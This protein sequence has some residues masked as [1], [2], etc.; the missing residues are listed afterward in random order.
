MKDKKKYVAP[1]EELIEVRVEKGFEQ[2]LGKEEELNRY[3]PTDSQRS[4]FN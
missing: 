4:K 1:M 3:V 2:S